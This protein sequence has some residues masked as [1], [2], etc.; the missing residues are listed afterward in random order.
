MPVLPAAS[1]AVITMTLDP[2]SSPTLALQLVVPV[3][4]PLLPRL[5]DHPTCATP[6]LSEAV[7]LMVIGVVREV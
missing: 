4:V 2:I 3:A 1:R 5:L 7:P 6:M